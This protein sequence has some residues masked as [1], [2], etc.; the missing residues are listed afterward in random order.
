M[1]DVPAATQ[2]NPLASRLR[3]GE[4]VLTGE[5]VPPV[6]GG[7]DELLALA[8]PFRE[9]LAALN[10]TDGPGAKV[11]MSSLAAAGILAQHGFNPVVQMTCRDRNRIA[12]QA[13]LLGASALG[14]RNALFLTGDDPTAGD[15]PD[16]KPVFDAKSHD[17]LSWSAKMSNEGLLPSGR[18][19]KTPPNFFCGAADV[20]LVPPPDWVPTELTRKADAGAHF[21]QTQLCYDID[22]VKAYV[23]ALSDHGL[24]ERLFILLGTGPL[25]S[26]RSARWMN[27]NLYGVDVPEWMIER[28]AKADDP[29]EEGRRL[30]LAFLAELKDIAGIH[31]VHLMAPGNVDALPRVIDEFA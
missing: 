18:S 17:L 10:V 30:C 4:F 5:I 22:V 26:A 19:I 25:G 14:V 24:T 9:G 7:P 13:D 1:D 28:L 6:S 23:G 8:E 2:D 20:P 31:G 29:K 15:Q 11:H 16:A 27:D 3:R 12:L 21:I